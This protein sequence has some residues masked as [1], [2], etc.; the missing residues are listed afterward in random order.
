MYREYR[1]PD[2]SC[3]G[4]PVEGSSFGVIWLERVGLVGAWSSGSD[5]FKLSLASFFTSIYKSDMLLSLF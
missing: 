3:E 1:L 4:K 2:S 5:E